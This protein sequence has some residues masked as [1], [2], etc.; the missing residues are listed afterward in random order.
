MQQKA[1]LDYLT[2]KMKAVQS[3]ERYLPGEKVSH[4]RRL[5]Y[6][7]QCDVQLSSIFSVDSCV[8]NVLERAYNC[9]LMNNKA[10]I[11]GFVSSWMLKLFQVQE[12]API[13][14]EAAHCLHPERFLLTQKKSSLEHE[15]GVFLQNFMNHAP[16]NM[17][18]HPRR[19]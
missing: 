7:V 6:S 4:T 12:W 13:H 18:S 17:A 19:L 9:F 1:H 5:E 15:V 10:C 14:S 2:L 16:R 11:S 3:F 8:M